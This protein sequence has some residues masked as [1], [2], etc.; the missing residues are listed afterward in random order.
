MTVRRWQEEAFRIFRKPKST[1]YNTYKR[2]VLQKRFV[3]NVSK[4]R[5]KLISEEVVE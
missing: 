1:G 5:E 2:D 3:A 4:Q